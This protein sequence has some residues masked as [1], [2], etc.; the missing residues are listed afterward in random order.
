MLY[1]REPVSQ[2]V[3]GLKNL[4]KS[5]N[6]LNKFLFYFL[7]V[8][9]YFEKQVF[10]LIEVLLVYTVVKVSHGQ[11]CGFNIHH[12]LGSSPSA[13]WGHCPLAL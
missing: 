7:L 11:L 2:A 5:I 1:K 4:M 6:C 3:V 13:N 12:T 10:F 8:T 9:L